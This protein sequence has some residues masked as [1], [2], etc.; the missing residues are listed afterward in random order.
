MEHGYFVIHPNTITYN[1]Y[2][3]GLT[4]S[5]CM[6]LIM[7]SAVLACAGPEGTNPVSLDKA[8]TLRPGQT[9]ELQAESLSVRFIRVTADSR[10]PRNVQCVWAGEVT[11][12]VAVTD[13]ETTRK[14]TIV[15]GATGSDGAKTVYKN[16]EMLT[17]VQPYPVAGEAIPP[18]AY[19]MTFTI[20]KL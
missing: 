14:L 16:Y 13:P 1:K 2:M 15:Q 11:S 9:A 17:T 8:F 7:I 18:D 12:E 6:A 19:R 3:R 5:I 10:C 20:K 4:Y